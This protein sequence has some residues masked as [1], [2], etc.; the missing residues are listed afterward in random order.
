MNYKN[1]GRI[2]GK[3]MVLEGI[4][5]LAPLL[6]S[7]IYGESFEHKLAF[8]IPIGILVLVG[9]LL[10][11]S[12]P[13]RKTLYQKEGFA[14]TA[15]VWFLMPLFGALPLVISGDIPNFNT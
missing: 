3:I 8:L 6:V 11:Q 2:L 13:E 10:Q 15:I 7:I 1:I 4:L 5:M 14:L 12:M 9:L